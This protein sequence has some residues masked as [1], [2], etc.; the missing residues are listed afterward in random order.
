MFGFW[1]NALLTVAAVSLLILAHEFGHF[2]MARAVGMR[3]EVFSIGFWKRLVGFKKGHTDYRISLI[4]LGGYVTVAGE[5]PEEGEGKPYEF[6]SKSPGQRAVFIVGGVAMNFVLAILLFIIAFSIGVPFAAARVG[7]T[8]QGSPAWRAGIRHGDKIS[9]IGDV[10]EP[11]FSDITSTV[12]LTN[13]ERVR[14]VVQ[15]DG[16]TVRYALKPQYTEDVG[17]R[18]V[19]VTPMM[20]PV[21]TGL[22]RIGGQD[23]RSPAQE[24]GLQLGD[25]VVSI[26]GVEVAS[27]SDLQRELNRY[28]HSE[29]SITVRRGDRTVQTQLVTEPT[30]RYV[31]GVSGLTTRIDSLQGDGM[32]QRAGLRVGDRISAVNGQPVASA[33]GLERSIQDAWGQ[34]TLTVLRGG[35]E[36]TRSLDVP[37]AAA[38][39][40]LF[41]SLTFEAGA[42]LAWVDPDGPAWEKGLRPGDT[43]ISRNGEPVE[44]WQDML[45]EGR[46]A[47]E[48]THEVR[49]Q[50]DDELFAAL[51]T[52]QREA[53]EP[54]QIGIIMDHPVSESRS[55]GP[56]GAARK[57]L[58]NT[59]RRL[60]EAVLLLKGFATRQVSP[61]HM[62]GIVTIAYASYRAAA[63]GLGKLLYMTAT[64]SAVIAFFNLL[65][66]PVLDGGHLL[67][68]AI[69][70]IRGR[71]VGERVM[72]AAQTVGF[73]L[74][75]AL[76]IY[77]TRNDIIRLLQ[78]N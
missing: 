67:F 55:Y 60:V 30:E 12:V 63:E 3:V 52:P 29:V 51:V 44:T 53:S 32:A 23:G 66:I 78:L 48:E 56:I 28:P 77:V 41:F 15:R 57:G 74:L 18:Y 47:G 38:L 76:V 43:I 16:Q 49:W 10:E 68:L 36:L 58:S 39:S 13:A 17:Y 46:R 35:D 70:K 62:G 45:R 34:V 71:R 50:R 37:H 4:P 75:L 59:V 40:E 14:V 24:A 69:E 31:I 27:A 22:T 64:I 20:E 5:S 21:I 61:R 1:I 6:W 42:K 11:V 73:V 65:P 54:G 19:G 9:A 72:A 8:V 2:I 33:V 7:Q 26:N 25:R